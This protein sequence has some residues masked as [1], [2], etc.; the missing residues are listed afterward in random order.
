ML[1]LTILNMEWTVH[2]LKKDIKKSAFLIAFIILICLLTYLTFYNLLFAIMAFV[3]LIISMRQFFVRTHYKLD[4][5]GVMVNSLGNRKKQSWNYFK[6]F[7]EDRKGILL[8]PFKDKSYLENFRGVY[9]ILPEN[10]R[11][12]ILDFIKQSILR[13]SCSATAKDESINPN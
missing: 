1:V 8:S 11:P 13:S 10:E 4:A 12:Q 2:P 3:L 5:E 6:S 7:Y 9:L